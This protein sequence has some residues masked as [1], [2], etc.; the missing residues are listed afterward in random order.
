MHIL[1][2]MDA[3]YPHA[4]MYAQGLPRVM[5]ILNA[6]MSKYTHAR[7]ATQ[8]RNPK[9]LGIKTCPFPKICILENTYM[10]HIKAS[11]SL[12]PPVDA[13][14]FLPVIYLLAAFAVAVVIFAAGELITLLIDIEKNT[15][16]LALDS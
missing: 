7:E 15:R 12:A 3:L 1:L 4:I 14:T 2:I 6:I 10:Q 9:V 5:A 11:Q 16:R 8:A 13:F